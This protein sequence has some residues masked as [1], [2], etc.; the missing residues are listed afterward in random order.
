MTF[1]LFVAVEHLGM[2]LFARVFFAS[3]LGG[4]LSQ[5]E[6]FD[7]R[8]VTLDIREKVLLAL[9]QGAFLEDS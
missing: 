7:Q 6:V 5:D 4:S 3:T 9:A 1:A 2:E 8:S